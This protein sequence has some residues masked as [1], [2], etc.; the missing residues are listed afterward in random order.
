MNAPA[1]FVQP[2]MR[3]KGPRSLN[4][5]P[6]GLF[7]YRGELCLKTEYRTGSGAVEAYIVSSGEFFW[8]DE[9]QTVES[10]LAQ[11]VTPVVLIYRGVQ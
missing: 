11:I 1:T 3:L 2:K 6:I 7:L 9:P 4:A 10:Q 8:G 5:A